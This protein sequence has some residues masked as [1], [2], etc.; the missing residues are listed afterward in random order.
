M[1]KSK[2]KLFSTIVI[3]LGI[4]AIALM[5]LKMTGIF[6]I[7][8]LFRNSLGDP[9]KQDSRGGYFIDEWVSEPF[10]ELDVTISFSSYDSG[11]I[12]LKLQSNNKKFDDDSF[13]WFYRDSKEN[14]YI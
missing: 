3:I 2:S 7:T 8:T 11:F 12:R 9:S 14:G 1:Q 5:L 10:G 6:D 13:S 4:V